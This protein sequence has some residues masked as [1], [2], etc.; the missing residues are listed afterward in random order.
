LIATPT[1]LEALLPLVREQP[2]VA[3]DTEADSLHCYFEK[4][5]LVQLAVPGRETLIDP[6]AGLSLQ[7]LFDAF[8]EKELVLHGADYDLRLLRRAGLGH[9]DSLFDTM[10]AARL[11][12]ITDFSLAALLK[13]FFG[14]EIPKSSQKANWARR[15]L[16]EKMVEYALGDVKHLF[17][18]ADL[19]AAELRRLGRTEWLRQSC[20]KLVEATRAPRERDEDNAWRIQGSGTLRGRP[21]AVLR[22]LWRWRDEE[23]RA[24]D[25]PPFHIMQNSALIDAARLF[26]SGG[27]VD[28]PHLRGGRRDRFF[29]AARRALAL[30]EKDWPKPPPRRFV[31][32]TPGQEERF[33]T[34]KRMR[35][36][37]ATEL[38]LDPSLLAPRAVMEAIATDA[39][40]APALLLPW[41]RE[42]LDL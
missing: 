27:S 26:H 6:L 23:A 11:T 7:P 4:L 41:Q 32:Q 30:P 16:P 40:A 13:R 22:A 36:A 29:D 25:R 35:D 39:D 20:A 28:A 34:M 12:G 5:C 9:V 1:E 3:L 14:E 18:L 24:V 21:A 15:P 19:L 42:V 31:K 33:E 17:E 8:A 2:R 37:R 38:G 10:I